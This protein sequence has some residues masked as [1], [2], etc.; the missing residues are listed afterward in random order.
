MGVAGAGD[1]QHRGRPAVLADP[2]H[3][4]GGALGAGERPGCEG[5]CDDQ[6]TRH[7]LGLQPVRLEI[8]RG[9]I[10]VNLL[11][12]GPSVESM[13]A[14]MD[15]HIA[16]Y[17][18]ETYEPIGEPAVEVWNCNWKL[19]WDNYQENYHIPI[20][21]PCLHRMVEETHEG[22]EFSGGVNF[23]YFKMRDKLSKVPHER[24]YQ[25]GIR[26][27]DH[28]FPEGKGS[29][30]LQISMDPNMGI[31]YYPDLFS[32]FQVLPLGVDKTLIKLTCYSP[33]NMSAQERE[34]QEINLAILDEVNEQ[35]KTLVARIQR[36]VRTSGYQPGPLAL[37]ESSV[38]RFHERIREF[39]P[40]TRLPEAPLQ[41][42]LHRENERLKA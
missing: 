14:P 40:V 25:E 18:P 3:E 38:Y 34:M 19:A 15:E 23:G 37:E 21:H 26:C 1:R 31:E 36:G 33:P 9:H 7:G 42:T 2:P 20:G 10:F 28:R 13:M 24:R 39:I 29:K 11:G 22:G 30:W 8:Y 41:G 12:D 4:L 6:H 27:M 5:G 17:A 32:L 16:P 35:D